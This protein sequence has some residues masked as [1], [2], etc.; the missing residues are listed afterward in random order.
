MPYKFLNTQKKLWK[1]QEN[2]FFESQKG[3][4]MD[5]NLTKEVLFCVNFRSTSSNIPWVLLS[6]TKK[7]KIIVPP[8]S[9][10]FF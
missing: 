5:I 4:N 3:Q 10:F 6:G 7:L 1:N 9:Y 2:D 8:N